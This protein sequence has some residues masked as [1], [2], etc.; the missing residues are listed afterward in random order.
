MI[1]RVN[2]QLTNSPTHQ[3][4]N[5]YWAA[6]SS[7]PVTAASAA[8]KPIFECVPSQNGLVVEP[9]QRHSAN[10]RLAIVYVAPFQSTS[11]TSSPSTRYGPFCLT[12]IVAISSVS[13]V[14]LGVLGASCSSASS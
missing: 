8:A 7:L 6:F 13:F 4:T 5:F 1:G 12:L 14:R 2:P 10:G 9:P 3:L 11:V